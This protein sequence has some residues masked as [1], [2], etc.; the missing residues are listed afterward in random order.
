MKIREHRGTLEDSLKTVAE[1]EPTLEAIA[2]HINK[3]DGSAISPDM[4]TVEEY[5]YDPRVLWATHLV[6]VNG[7]AWGMTDGPIRGRS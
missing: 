5:G 4:I 7:R 2:A 1:I 3:T 6:S